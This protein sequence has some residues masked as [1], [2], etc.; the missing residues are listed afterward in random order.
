MHDSKSMRARLSKLAKE[1][2]VKLLLSEFIGTA[3]LLAVGL[4]I[5][6][7]N[8][9]HGSPVLRWIPSVM[10]RR[11]LTG[12]L[13][14]SVGAAIAFSEV[15][16]VSGAHIN[17]SVSL[18][19]FLEKKIHFK[20]FLGYIAAQ[21]L[22]AIV[23]SLPLLLFGSMGKSIAYGAAEVGPQGVTA[24]I[25]GEAVTTFCLIM[26][27]F[28]F[29]GSHSLRRFTPLIIPP[30]YAVM[31]VLEAGLSGTSTNLARSLGPAVISGWWS[32]FYVYIIGPAAGVFAA[33]MLRK[34]KIFR[35]FEVEVAKLYRFSK[36][37]YHVLGKSPFE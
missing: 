15:G 33:I 18:A 21:L 17:P 7:L 30:L 32:G 12:I 36:D 14:G 1:V 27:L 13:F 28:I 4:S 37:P 2:P 10:W 19:F 8:F 35:S 31:I 29:L 25:A 6:I 34:M 24:A 9:G 20:L 16:K 23:G 11:A 26:G 5:V 3:L 22:G